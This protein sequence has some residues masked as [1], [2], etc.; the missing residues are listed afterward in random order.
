MFWAFAHVGVH[1]QVLGILVYL[2]WTDQIPVYIYHPLL[3][4]SIILTA[5]I[6]LWI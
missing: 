1:V 4:S 3:L 5:D 2:K 6:Y